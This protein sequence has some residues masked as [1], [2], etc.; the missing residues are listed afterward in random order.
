MIEQRSIEY[1]PLRERHGQP[2]HLWPIWFMGDA[3]LATLATGLIGVKYGLS[4]AW[5]ATAIVL[6]TAFGTFFMAFHATQG[7]Q[8]GLPQM[9]QSRPQF[10][11]RG[12]MLV[13][14]V[15]LA[16][17]IGFNAFNLL[18]AGDTL[19]LLTG[20]AARPGYVL[21]MVAAL[22]IA[23]VGHDWIHLAQRVLAAVLIVALLVFSAGAFRLHLAP[24]LLAT[25]GFALH[26]FLAQFFAVASY[27]LTWAIYVSDYS[28]YLPRDV[29]ARSCFWWT[30]GGALFGGAW[31]A[32]VGMAVAA[33]APGLDVAP[34][35]RLAGD[36]VFP[37]FGAI[38]LTGCLLGL[39][40]ITS[41]NFYGASLTLLAM[42]DSFTKIRLSAAARVASLIAVALAVM[43]ITLA[44]SGDFVT[45]FA[46]LLSVLL[47]LF[48][49][50]TAINLVDFYVVRRG[51]YSVREIFRANGMYGQWNWRGLT[52]YAAGFAAM[53]PFFNTGLYEGAAARALGG[54]DLAMVVGLPVSALVYLFACRS[55][56]VERDRL[57][58]TAADAGLEGVA[59][60]P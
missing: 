24:A 56:D 21:F 22:A 33:V 55:M 48:T 23:V 58:A 44:S 17:Y 52:A 15:A 41:L 32:L 25:H 49:P 12:A 30:Y 53:V 59:S 1:V 16:T 37:G 40:T 34:S 28:R 51:H 4:L 35:V 7:P 14:V 43:A 3:N 31:M 6:G 5:S 54:V 27:Q 36:Q 10:G 2:W 42:A 45:G 57:R 8:L 18:L 60:P 29:G 20:I 26:P 38:L 39:V 50:W 47:Y 9:I 13:W 19:H 46:D 11:Y